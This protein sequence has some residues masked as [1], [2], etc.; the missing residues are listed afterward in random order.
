MDLWWPGRSRS[1]AQAKVTEQL[2]NDML[3]RRKM[4]PARPT[5]RLQFGKDGGFVWRPRLPSLRRQAVHLGSDAVAAIYADASSCDVGGQPAAI[6][7]SRANSPNWTGV[8]GSTGKSC[9]PPRPLWSPGAI[10]S[11]AS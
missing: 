4:L 11:R 8:R 6:F 3:R 10:A 9:G 7:T 5:R 1:S 2:R